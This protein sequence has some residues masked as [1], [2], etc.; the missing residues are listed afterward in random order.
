M[1]PEGGFALVGARTL[2]RADIL[3]AERRYY[4]SSEGESFSREVVIHRGAVA[5]VVWTGSH[6]VLISQFR[7]A[8]GKNLIEVPAGKLDV[9]GESPADA[10]VRE[11][12]EEVGYRP[13][14]VELLTAF[15]TAAGFCDEYMRL[16]LATNLVIEPPNPAGIEERHATIMHVAIDE[17]L[18]MVTDGVIEDAKT[19][20]GLHMLAA[21]LG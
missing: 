4:L 10:I 12:Q 6:V 18:G 19:I 1:N 16:Y 13:Q 2:L 15:Y 3:H 17:A 9:D 20:I 8:T 5:A 11:C 14:S 7:A 21:R